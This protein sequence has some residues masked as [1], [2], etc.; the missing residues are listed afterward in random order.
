[1]IRV[2]GKSTGREEKHTKYQN[3][4]GRKYVEHLLVNHGNMVMNIGMESM[5]VLNEEIKE[6]LSS[7]THLINDY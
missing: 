5:Y 6:Y 1:M 4:P 7:T 3:P 2:K